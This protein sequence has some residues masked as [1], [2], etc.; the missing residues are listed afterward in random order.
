MLATKGD[1]SHIMLDIILV[2][3]RRTGISESPPLQQNNSQ[4]SNRMHKISRQSDADL[5]FKN[6]V[7]FE[8]CLR[9]SYRTKNVKDSYELSMLV[10]ASVF[11]KLRYN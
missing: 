2:L 1:F 6:S 3:S 10:A 8:I 5:I 9:S 7:M 11:F 4:V